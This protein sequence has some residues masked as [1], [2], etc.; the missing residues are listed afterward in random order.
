[1]TKLFTCLL[2]VL[3][4]A[5]DAAG[6]GLRLYLDNS[7][8]TGAHVTVVPGV[9]QAL[10]VQRQAQLDDVHYTLHFRLPS[11]KSV[12]VTGSAEISFVWKGKDD[13]QLDFQGQLED[14]AIEV[15][16]KKRTAD[17]RDEH[18]VVSRTLLKK[19]K[20]NRLHMHFVSGDK[21]LNRNDDYLYTL[22]VPDHARS[23]FPC[24]DQPDIKARFSLTLTL[25]AEWT[26]L[27]NADAESLAKTD[28]ETQQMVFRP[29]D[30]L[31]TYLFSFTAG[32]FA[33]KT[34]ERDGRRLT[35]L[36]RE[37]DP[38]KVA[39]LDTVFDQIALSLRWLEDYTGISQPFQKYGIV[40]LPGYQFGGM[41]HPGC[42]QL[43]DRTVFLGE[44]PTLD[45]ELNRLNLLAHET[46]HLWFGDLVTMRWF[47][48]VWTK[49]VF[50]NF[51]ADKIAREQFPDI[52]HDLNFIKTHYRPALETDRT[53]GTHPI[54]Q[55]LDNLQDAGQL[56]GNIIYH[57]APIMMR[58]LEERMGTSAFRKA[59]QTYLHTY[60]Y[61]NATWDDLI[62]IFDRENPTAS[63]R[64]FDTQ[65]VKEKGLKPVPIISQDTDIAP[66]A[67]GHYELSASQLQWYTQHWHQL[68][69]TKR[70]AATLYL[71]ESWLDHKLSREEAFET[72]LHG[73]QGQENAL[74][75]STCSSMLLDIIG[76]TEGESRAFMESRLYRTGCETDRPALRRQVLQGLSRTAT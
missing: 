47:N 51:M 46:S 18:I 6:E 73:L 7:Q 12:P 56:Y 59:L 60:A 70:Y 62:D 64:D 75:A 1:M 32:R 26:A 28:T 54:Q 45:E 25:P 2:T 37:K 48:D 27:S 34:V 61:S 17:Y 68:P 43:R 71:Y 55:P 35:A 52:N 42:I 33:T 50:A 57:K 4:F 67:Y 22:F 16:G 66:F 44:H 9:S 29:S 14:N 36:Y 63:I 39:Q 41:E 13:L 53:D 11:E 24:F 76:E 69:E 5:T 49:E 38:Q 74:V 19:G 65:W 21:A 23:V 30:P 31:P 40:I 20:R 15:N 72:L 3:L 58:Q 8:P 10:A